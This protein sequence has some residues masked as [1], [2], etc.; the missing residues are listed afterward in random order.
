[1]KIKKLRAAAAVGNHSAI[2]IASL[3]VPS[4]S[5][6][7]LANTPIVVTISSLA[8]NPDKL[9]A[10]GCHSPKPSGANNGEIKPPMLARSELLISSTIPNDPPSNPNVDNAQITKH[11]TTR[12]VPALIKN[13]LVL[14]QTCINTVFKLG[15]WYAGSSITNGAG[16]PEKG[17]VFFRIIAETRT[18]TIPAKYINGAINP[19]DS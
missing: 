16:L 12:I 15:I 5:S 11:A 10:T 19:A 7:R 9:A 17:L 8:A 3:A 1:M 6:P 4:I 18:A 14:S 13:A 2:T